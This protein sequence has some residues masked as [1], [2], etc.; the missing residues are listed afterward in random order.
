AVEDF[1]DEDA[2]GVKLTSA[3]EEPP[4]D[5]C[6]AVTNCEDTI[7]GTALVPHGD[8]SATLDITSL[9]NYPRARDTLATL[10]LTPVHDPGATAPAARALRACG[11][12]GEP[13]STPPRSSSDRVSSATT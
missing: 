5:T 7:A 3:K 4:L 13:R 2:D 12:A 9:V 6:G 8:I 10:T 11:A 1:P